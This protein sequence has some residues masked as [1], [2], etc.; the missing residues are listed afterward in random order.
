MKARL[1]FAE[2]NELAK[3]F[4]GE[5]S[6]V[7]TELL[8]AVTRAAAIANA[9]AAEAA[10]KFTGHGAGS[11]MA[12]G[13][14]IENF[15][16]RVRVRDIVKTGRVQMVVHDLGRRVG[17]AAPPVKAIRR[18]VHLMQRRG[19][20]TIGPGQTLDQVAFLIARSIKQRGQKAQHFMRDAGVFVE[21]EFV[22][23]VERVIRG[24]SDR[25]NRG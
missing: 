11:I 19:K 22:A 6:R 23:D 24:F 9:H 17:A 21:P 1:N 14:R 13:A 16:G 5:E 18:W 7:Q 20:I 8:A 3:D 25:I 15:G 2:M 12:R 4:D 10:P